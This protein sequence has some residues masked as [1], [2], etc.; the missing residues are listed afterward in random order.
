MTATPQREHKWLQKLI[1]EWTWEGEC[2][3][4]PDQPPWKSTGT[5]RVRGI[6]DMWVVGEGESDMPDGGRALNIMTL[7]YDP[8][9]KHFIGTFIAS[10]M[11]HLWVYERGELDE[12]ERVLTLHAE[13]PSMSPDEKG[14]MA[15]YRDV[16][17]LKSD[18]HRT[19]TAFVRGEDGT[20]TQFM[21]AHYRR[22]TTSL[23]TCGA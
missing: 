11:T 17:E 2:A 22:T 7:G 9:K 16:I 18:D 4:G 21:Q 20:W 14:K 3:M 13:G 1:G 8:Q 10:V 5:E 15:Q 23:N 6:G 19:L 12:A